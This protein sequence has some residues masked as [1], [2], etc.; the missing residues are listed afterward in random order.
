MQGSWGLGGLL[1]AAA[2]GLLSDV[3]RLAW[4]VVD[5][6]LAGAG[7]HLRAEVQ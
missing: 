6:H 1:S 5:R 3:D 7:D 2:Y 4:P